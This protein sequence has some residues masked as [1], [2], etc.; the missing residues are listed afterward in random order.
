MTVKV[1]ITIIL[2]LL[3]VPT[4]GCINTIT[5]DVIHGLKVSIGLVDVVIE[6]IVVDLKELI[7]VIWVVS[8]VGVVS[9]GIA[10]T[11][12][13]L[14][15]IKIK[16]TKLFHVSYLRVVQLVCSPV[17]PGLQTMCPCSSQV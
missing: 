17:Y 10:N 8:N 11:V 1:I 15:P 16:V 5:D 2:K 14:I 9:D 4:V 6:M 3:V 12:D 7:V 13:L